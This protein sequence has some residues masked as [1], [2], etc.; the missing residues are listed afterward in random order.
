MLSVISTVEI[1]NIND[2]IVGGV[3]I[4]LKIDFDNSAFVAMVMCVLCQLTGQIF[5]QWNHGHLVA[6][7]GPT[8]V[9]VQVFV[10]KMLHACRQVGFSR[11]T[12]HTL[13]VIGQ[14]HALFFIFF[15]TCWT[16]V[17]ISLLT[18]VAVHQ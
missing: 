6:C 10:M 12:D 5:A 1:V 3:L 15:I 8:N 17:N 7:C 2:F 14:T 4:F 11:L 9:M 16:K 13:V 18:V